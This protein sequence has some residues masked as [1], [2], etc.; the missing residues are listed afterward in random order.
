MWVQGETPKGYNSERFY[1]VYTDKFQRV[2]IPKFG[3]MNIRAV[4]ALIRQNLSEIS[5]C[6]NPSLDCIDIFITMMFAEY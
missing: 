6:L 4:M 5:G 1:S 3:M 2:V